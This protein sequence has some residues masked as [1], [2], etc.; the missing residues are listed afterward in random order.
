QHDQAGR[1]QHAAADDGG[2]GEDRAPTGDEMAVTQR[3]LAEG[4]A[5]GAAGLSSGLFTAPGPFAKPDE[6]QLLLKEKR[7]G[8]DPSIIVSHHIGANRLSKSFF[9]RRHFDHAYGQARFL[10]RERHAVLGSLPLAVPAVPERGLD[11]GG[12]PAST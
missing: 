1:S 7:I 4:L 6:N 9:L 5:P 8:Y 11:D 3:L 12:R 10:S 2:H